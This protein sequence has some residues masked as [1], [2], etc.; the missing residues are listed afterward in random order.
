MD[1]PAYLPDLNPIENVWK[2]L[3]EDITKEFPH[4]VDLPKN[5]AA[6]R[7]LIYVTICVWEGLDEE[8]LNKLLLGMVKRL[9]AVIEA[10][11]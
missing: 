6:K 1:W 2:I 5:D 4:L 10:D 7:E 8:M 3:K 9:Q 11:G